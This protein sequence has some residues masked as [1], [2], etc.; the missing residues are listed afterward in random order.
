MNN[1]LLTWYGSALNFVILVY[2][3]LA[4]LNASC[5][6]F[7]QSL[8]ASIGLMSSLLIHIRNLIKGDYKT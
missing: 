1:E 4:S 2:L 6:S 8:I 7:S 5:F 3:I